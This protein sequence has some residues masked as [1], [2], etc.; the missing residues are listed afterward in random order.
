VGIAA[1][2]LAQTIRAGIQG[3]AARLIAL[4][5]DLH[6]HPEV[7]YQEHG[8]VRRILEA[9]RTYPGIAVEEGSA[10]LP[11]AFRAWVGSDSGPA[12]GIICEYDALPGLGHGCGHNLIAASAAG[13]L[14]GLAPVASR[15]PGKV[16]VIGSP[17]EEGGGGKILLAERGTYDGLAAV[18]QTHPADRHRLSGP[19][20][21]LAT[22]KVE[23]RGRAAHVG[24]AND[25][26]VNALDAL[27][28]LFNAI[29]ALRQQIRD[30]S[31][32][33]G[34]ITR[35]GAALHTIP[36]DAA[37]EIGVRATSESY[38]DELVS[39][40]E[41]CAQG[42]ATATG[43][44]VSIERSHLAHYPPMKL[45]RTLGRLLG[46]TLRS[47]GENVEDFPPGFE[48]YANDVAAVS[49]VAPAALLN[50]KIGPPGLAEH[51]LEFVNA[52]AS[53]EGHRGML[54]AATTMA[55]A[56]LALL[57]DADLRERVRMEFQEDEA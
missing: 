31:R 5:R 40:V 37:A 52:A 2:D 20:I 18:L 23:F 34:I 38:L 26:G 57:A 13:V 33:Y 4:S 16:I 21:G 42:A 46:E 55:L 47:L 6:A 25:R 7:A 48:G 56:A 17:A 15:L 22:M 14:V 39:R 28:L 30:G 35:G 19:T 1:T 49:R 10:G 45:N 27:L 44:A 50:Y 3:E 43:C 8:S 9:L 54:L 51:S 24:S 12:V 36:D 53:D 29:N 41:A 32:I 11:T